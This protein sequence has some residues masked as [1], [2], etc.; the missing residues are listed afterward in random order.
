MHD[1][2]AKVRYQDIVTPT[3]PLQY[4]LPQGSP[5]SPI[6]FLLYTEPIYRLGNPKGRFGYADDAGIL[7]TGSSVD[8][9]ATA[10]SKYV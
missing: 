10:A 4:S 1:R 9:T 6:L 5:V 8:E 2:S 3:S 7:C